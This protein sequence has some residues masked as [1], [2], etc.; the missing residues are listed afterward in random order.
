M[1]LFLKLHREITYKLPDFAACSDVASASL[2]NIQR[3]LAAEVGRAPAAVCEN[4]TFDGVGLPLPFSRL[5]GQA[6]LIL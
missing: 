1:A 6:W 2:R 5:P 4:P 3:A